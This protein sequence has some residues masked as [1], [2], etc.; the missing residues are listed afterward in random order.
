[1]IHVVTRGMLL[2]IDAFEALAL[3]GIAVVLFHSITTEPTF[4]LKRESQSIVREI[5]LEMEEEDG[6]WC[7]IRGISKNSQGQQLGVMK[8]DRVVQVGDVKIPVSEHAFD[9]VL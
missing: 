5:E 2:W 8:E 7:C 1:M 3:F 4:R 6:Q 9:M